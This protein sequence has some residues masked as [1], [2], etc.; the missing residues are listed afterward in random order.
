M[1]IGGMMINS[2]ARVYHNERQ[3]ERHAIWSFKDLEVSMHLKGLQRVVSIDVQTS[4]CE[5]MHGTRKDDKRKLD[6]QD[7]GGT[8]TRHEA[9]YSRE[10]K[11]AM[12]TGHGNEKSNGIIWWIGW[13]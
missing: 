2:N 9:L 6:D 3:K 13:K 5:G 4:S 8:C 10:E 11:G 12:T 7:E 1:K